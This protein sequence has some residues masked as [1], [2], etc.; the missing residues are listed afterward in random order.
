MINTVKI[1]LNV[2]REIHAIVRTLQNKPV[3]RQGRGFLAYLV[4]GCVRD[5][6]INRE[7]KDWDITTNAEP[8][9]IIA[10]FP[11][12]VYENRFGT[13]TVVNE[14]AEK[15]SLKNVEVTPFRTEA[16][17]SDR[18][19]PDEVKFSDK[20]EDDLSR[21]DFTI[22]ALAYDPQTEELI[23]LYNGIK[24][25]NDHVLKTVGNPN[26]RFGEDALRMLRAIR[27]ASELRFTCNNEII[28]SISNNNSLI[29]DISIERIRDEFIKII[30]SPE[31]MAGLI[32]SHKTGLLRYFLPELEGGIGMEQKG[33]HVYDIWE[34]TL[35]SLQHAADKNY[36]L[37]VKLAAIF[38]DIGKIK[39][40]RQGENG[41][42]YTFY[43][44]EVVGERMTREI[45]TRLKFSN[46]MIDL[47]TKMVRGHMFFADP[48][49]ITLSAVRR[50]IAN[51]GHDYI[52]DL[53]NLRICD[54][55][56]MGRPKEEPYRLRKYQ[57]MIEEALRAPTSVGM[58]KIDGKQIMAVTREM[59]GPK[60]GYIL[61]ALL[62]EA[63]EKPDINTK[64]YLED[65]AKEL[66]KLPE[67]ELK[68]LAEQ[69][70]GKKEEVEQAE[71][72]KIREKY[73]VK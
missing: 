21:R 36:A 46:K 8:E 4:G 61:N 23:D 71:L 66:A 17:Y 30:D 22:N 69:G 53:M 15:I 13:V 68:K 19:H 59:P 52:W 64:E 47:V 41:K 10:L 33:E 5:C 73:H 9:E 48:D 62:E 34:H 29:R 1:K 18:R 63:L 35:R 6:L 7:P 70:K 56:G 67:K 39:T 3:D 57:S 42:E 11:K 20:L 65:K 14:E 28:E 43:G 54:R 12:T 25:I 38:H 37:H 31:P 44:H 50:V 72:K 26:E 40:R 60:I 16:N 2:P 24:D 45:M 51:I 27:L 58:L 55:V 32:L 49:K